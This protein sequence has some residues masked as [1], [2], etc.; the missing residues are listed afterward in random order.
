MHIDYIYI[1][2][3]T[4]CIYIY[5]QSIYIYTQSLCIHIYIYIYICICICK[6]ISLSFSTSISISIPIYLYLHLYIS[7]SLFLSLSL[8]I[9]TCTLLAW[10]PH[11]ET[12]LGANFKQLQVRGSPLA[13]RCT[14]ETDGWEL[15]GFFVRER[16]RR[17]MGGARGPV[18]EERMV[19]VGFEPELGSWTTTF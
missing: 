13:D 15:H 3:Y 4:V 7:L 14:A 17:G 18:H 11:E 12:Y 2:S 8:F 19:V 1:C 16:S 9:C 6:W 10:N 5:I